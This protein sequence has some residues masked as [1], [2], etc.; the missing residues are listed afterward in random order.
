MAEPKAVAELRAGDR[1]P[2]DLCGHLTVVAV[3]DDRVT[4]AD[5]PHE[6]E[7]DCI[8]VDVEPE[9]QSTRW[10]AD[11]LPAAAGSEGATWFLGLRPLR[12]R[13]VYLADATVTL[14]DRDG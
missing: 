5:T 11:L 1:I 2:T 12:Y 14:E 8:L 9:D 6:P 13:L 3:T 7:Q 10:D 4:W